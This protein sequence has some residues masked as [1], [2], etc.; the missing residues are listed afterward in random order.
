[1]NG[2]SNQSAIKTGAA[3]ISSRLVAI[4][5]WLLDSLTAKEAFERTLERVRVWYGCYITGYVVMPER[6]HLLIS[7]TGTLA[8]ENKW[9]SWSWPEPTLPQKTREGWGNLVSL[10]SERMGLSSG[11]WGL[12]ADYNLRECMSNRSAIKTSAPA[13]RHVYFLS[14]DGAAR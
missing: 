8:G 5:G 6:V 12:C 2:V 1:V 9:V 7:E 11:G 4:T 3:C 10:D 14:P 13:F